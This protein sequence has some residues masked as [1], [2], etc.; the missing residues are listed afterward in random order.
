MAVR[1]PVRVQSMRYEVETNCR[2]GTMRTR[3]FTVAHD[4]W[5]I[6]KPRFVPLARGRSGQLF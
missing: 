5:V 4:C 3:K 6:I 1:R 2:S